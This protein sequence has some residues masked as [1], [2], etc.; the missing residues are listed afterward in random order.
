MNTHDT[1]LRP[2]MVWQ[3]LSPR[4]RQQLL[5]LLGQWVLRQWQAAPPSRPES[6]PP[7][8]GQHEPQ[9]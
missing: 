7:T 6:T 4:Q 2:L 8:G 3:A 5:S 1:R 9:G